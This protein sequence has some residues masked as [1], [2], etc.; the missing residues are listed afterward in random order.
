M[1]SASVAGRFPA[2]SRLSH[3]R[4]RP[5]MFLHR[6]APGQSR[7]PVAA[8]VL[9]ALLHVLFFAVVAA[10]AIW[11]A[12]SPPKAYV[13]NLVPM[14]AAVG[15]PNAPPSTSA[16][17]RTPAPAAS[18]PAPAA[19]DPVPRPP[20][21]P[22]PREPTPREPVAREPVRLPD[23]SFST[24]RLPSRAAAVLRPGEKELPPLAGPRMASAPSTS[25]PEKVDKPT[26]SRPGPTPTLGQ[27]T[28]SPVGAGALSV[29]ASDFPHAWYVRQVIQKVEAEWKRQNRLSEPRQRP[30]L[31]FEIQRDGSI[32]LPTLKE[33]S[34]NPV[35]DQAALRAVVDASP[36]PPLPQDWARPALGLELRFFLSNPG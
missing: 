12:W 22:T 5:P 19:S 4:R 23:P 26:D 16:P 27:A 28:G 7:V 29:N 2:R 36:F 9:S 34:G 18:A 8:I 13:V 31:L 35:Y 17:V 20:R 30:L 25:K 3:D 1:M 24:P 21:E 33:S 32:K 10:L 14:V 6:P 11:T 15:L